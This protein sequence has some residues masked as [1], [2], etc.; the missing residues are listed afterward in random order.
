MSDV[1]KLD[2]VVIGAGQ[3]GLAS[4]YELARRGVGPVV[5][6]AGDKVG[7]QWRNRWDSLRL[8]TPA[9]FDGLPGSQFPAPPDSFPDKNQLA[10]Y[11]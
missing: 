3:A 4:A 11:L 8:F 6:E 9:R 10:D 7:N 1:E 5:L 2:A